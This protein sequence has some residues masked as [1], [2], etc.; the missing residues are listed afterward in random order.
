MERSG[1]LPTTQFSFRKGLGACDAG[2]LKTALESGL[3]VRIARFISTQP[4][5]GSTIREFSVGSALL[6][7]EVLCCLYWN[8]FYQTDGST[9]CG[10]C[11]DCT[12]CGSCS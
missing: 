10:S 6:V 4:F 11:S 5:I 1:V 3:E 7:L 12:H 2:T 8:S 9:H